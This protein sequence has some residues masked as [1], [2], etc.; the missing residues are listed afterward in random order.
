MIY[1]LIT[2]ILWTSILLILS[3]FNYGLTSK[4][5][6]ELMGNF[7][8]LLVHLPIGIFILGFGL[9]LFSRWK[10]Q[11]IPNY[12]QEFILLSTI[13]CTFL[14]MLSGWLL[15][16]GGGYEREALELHR[17]MGIGFGIGTLVLYALFKKG[18]PG[19][20]KIYLP[21]YS[22]LLIVLSV[23]G[24]YGGN[25]THG[26]GFL[27]GESTSEITSV[28]VS[29]LQKALVYEDLVAPIL[30]AKCVSCHKE[31]KTKGG[32][33]MTSKESL[34]K[35]GEHGSVFPTE[36][37]SKGTLL[38]RIHLDMQ[39]KLH[40]PP[41]SKTQL[42]S[43]EIDL[44]DWWISNG[45]CFDCQV[46]SL[47][48]DEKTIK[49]LSA[50][51]KNES[52]LET[53]ALEF[54]PIPQQWI[55]E[56]AA[57]GMSA[58]P[59]AAKSPLMIVNVKGKKDLNKSDFKLL[60][61]YAPQIVEL[62]LSYSN[63]N[64]TLAVFLSDFE[65]LIKIQMSFT[66]ITDQSLEP[67][68]E[69]KYLSSLN[70]FSTDLTQEA[71]EK[72]SP[73]KNLKK[74]YLSNT[75]I[76][77]EALKDFNDRQEKILLEYV[78]EETFAQT[79]LDPPKIVSETDFFKKELEISLAYIFEDAN[80]YYTLDG[81][82]PDTLSTRYT[83]PFTIR[84]SSSV[85]AITHKK[86]WGMSEVASADF[87]KS[88]LDYKE[89]HL[90]A[91]PNEKYAA[92]GGKSL[93]DL[94]RGST[95]FVDGMW[96]GFEGI[97]SGAEI[98]LRKPEVIHSVSVGALSA[99][100]SW[101][102]FPTAI[103]VYASTNGTDYKLIAKKSFEPIAPTNDISKKFFDLKIPDTQTQ[104]FKVVVK[105]PLKNPDWHP[106]PGGKSWLFIDEIILD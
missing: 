28:V 73:I 95:N 106:N 35:G 19:L 88:A 27:F 74:A 18:G 81:S 105:S 46:D 7:H 101:I 21:L 54:E 30:E 82:I 86:G 83:K 53:L 5:S 34:V 84:A 94:K 43:T 16:Q 76:P 99:P 100:A 75:Q 38:E 36:Q 44:L 11:K 42:S 103:E 51:E 64:D 89:V 80:L 2:P 4:I 33:L 91:Q 37:N 102:F 6:L 9:E 55:S 49:M 58:Y 93:V 61:K 70:A 20:Q 72:I 62:N 79:S 69:L 87:R 23:T 90:L 57:Y 26:E 104:H 97:H 63:M 66:K 39:D 22:G 25:M 68:T 60:K 78:A 14:S 85:R 67:L 96:L 50:F 77:V 24:H 56:V 92:Q 15:G 47:P 31:T 17:N 71:L 48:K 45:H 59:I 40:M 52:L 12:I 98:T 3:Y 8:P 10:K 32:L 29:D 41:K 65:H 1:K 13:L